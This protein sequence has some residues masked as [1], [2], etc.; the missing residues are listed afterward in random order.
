MLSSCQNCKQHC[1]G[2]LCIVP[3]LA[4]LEIDGRARKNGGS[5]AL[6]RLTAIHDAL[7]DGG[8]VAAGLL[9]SS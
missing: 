2:G 1:A 4:G 8:E 5:Y 6:A 9:A 7:G 3:D